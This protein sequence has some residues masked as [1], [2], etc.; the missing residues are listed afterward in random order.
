MESTLCSHI[1]QPSQ[2]AL[3]QCSRC[4]NIGDMHMFHFKMYISA[5]FSLIV[6]NSPTVTWYMC[7]ELAAFICSGTR[8]VGVWVIYQVVAIVLSLNDL[9]IWVA[10]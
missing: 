5:V 10:H 7:A 2:R 1:L 8:S 3:K 4:L 6:M 9:T